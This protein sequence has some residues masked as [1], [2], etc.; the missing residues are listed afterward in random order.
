MGMFNYEHCCH[1]QDILYCWLWILLAQYPTWLQWWCHYLQCYHHGNYTL[2]QQLYNV[3]K[4]MN[5]DGFTMV[6]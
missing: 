2:L 4:E 5:L 3:R 1:H 6:Y